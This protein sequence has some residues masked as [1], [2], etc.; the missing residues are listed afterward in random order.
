[1]WVQEGKGEEQV[2]RAQVTLARNLIVTGRE[3]WCW[4]LE[5]W[6][7]ENSFRVGGKKQPVCKLMGKI[8][9]KLMMQ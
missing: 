7:Q 8:E 9:E 1:M 6:G 2:E 5:K 3:N 4:L